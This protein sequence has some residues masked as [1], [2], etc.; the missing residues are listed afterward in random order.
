MRNFL[1]YSSGLFFWALTYYLVAI[2][3]LA[4]D[5]PQSQ[6]AIIWFPAGVAVAAFLSAHRSRWPLVLLAL[7]VAK[8][9]LDNHG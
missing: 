3:S 2:A 1:R 5:D 9:L 4:F 8:V 7:L 6:R